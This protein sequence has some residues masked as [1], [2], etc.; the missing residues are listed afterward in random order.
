MFNWIPSHSA[1]FGNEEADR[2]VSEATHF[3]RINACIPLGCSQLKNITPTKHPHHSHRNLAWS[4]LVGTLLQQNGKRLSPH[5]N[6]HPYQTL[7]REKAVIIHRFRLGYRCNWEI[8]ERVKRKC[9]HCNN[10]TSEPFL[11][12]AHPCKTHD[13]QNST[14]WK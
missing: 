11:H 7:P 9:I 12:Y 5:M 14:S 3:D 4:G 6:L 10:G 8:A 1:I 2:A 13:L